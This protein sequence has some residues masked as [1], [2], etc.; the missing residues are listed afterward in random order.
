VAY[1]PCRSGRQ[2]RVQTG[3]VLTWFWLGSG[4]VPAWSGP[5]QV[6]TL[7][8]WGRV[9]FFSGGGFLIGKGKSLFPTLARAGWGFIQELGAIQRD[10]LHPAEKVVNE[11]TTI[12]RR[13]AIYL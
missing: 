4:L 7:P 10:P 2:G 12:D 13:S 11:I 6:P 8:L 1:R 3:L 5:F 9:G